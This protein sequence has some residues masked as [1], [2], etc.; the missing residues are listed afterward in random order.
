MLN[1]PGAEEDPHFPEYKTCEGRMGWGICCQ[2]T[3]GEVSHGFTQR[4]EAS[5]G[6][7][8]YFRKTHF[9]NCRI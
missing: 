7:A 8:V 2:P 3:S 5:L 4:N 9:S 1:R 6:W